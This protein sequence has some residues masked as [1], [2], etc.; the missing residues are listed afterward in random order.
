MLVRVTIL[1]CWLWGSSYDGFTYSELK[2]E[3]RANY[4]DKLLVVKTSNEI[5]NLNNLTFNVGNI[6]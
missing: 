3:A 1:A 4:S 2:A 6:Q 5:T